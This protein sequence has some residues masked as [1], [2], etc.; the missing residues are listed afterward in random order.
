M[1][2]I[3][4]EDEKPSARRLKRMLSNLD[5]EAEVM[6][7]SVEESIDWFQKNVHPDLIFLD[8]QMPTLNGVDLLKR[9]PQPP[10]TI[11]TTVY[12]DYAIDAFDLNVVDYLLEPFAFERFIQALNKT[13]AACRPN[14]EKA[15]SKVYLTAKVDEKLVRVR[16]DEI[17]YIEGM[18]EYIRIVCPEEKYVTFERLKT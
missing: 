16:I 4:I 9:L 15:E 6:L 10:A 3:I 2:V 13:Q 14:I 17:V 12:K 1:N 7:H 18:K 11:F 8:I 5:I